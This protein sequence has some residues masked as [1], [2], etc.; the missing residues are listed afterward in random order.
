[1]AVGM[2]LSDSIALFGALG[3][4]AIVAV[5]YWEWEGNRL[6]AILHEAGD[7]IYKRNKIFSEY[8]RVESSHSASRSEAF[9]DKLLIDEELRTICD[10]N[11]RLMSRL[12][13]QVPMLFSPLR[14]QALEWHVVT[15]MWEILG[16]YVDRR[17]NTAGPSFA[18]PFLKYALASA[19]HLLKQ[20]RN[21]WTIIDPSSPKDGKHV[22]IPRQRLEHMQ[23]ELRERLK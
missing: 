21:D 16:P 4:W 11:V 10:D 1:M 5:I 6:D 3:E 15:F 23:Q 22:V 7:Q 9:A 19:G 13:A 17:R 8:C 14:R 2:T 20:R 18:K 12:G